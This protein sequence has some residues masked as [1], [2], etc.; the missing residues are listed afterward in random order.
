MAVYRGN[1]LKPSNMNWLHFTTFPIE[2]NRFSDDGNPSK[3]IPRFPLTN[4]KSWCII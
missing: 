4:P 1:G 2:G 3:K